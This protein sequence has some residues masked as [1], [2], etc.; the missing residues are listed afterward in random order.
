MHLKLKQKD[1][2]IQLLP[3]SSIIT[4]KEY[5]FEIFSY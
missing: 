2:D 1:C 4:N 5:L 3:I